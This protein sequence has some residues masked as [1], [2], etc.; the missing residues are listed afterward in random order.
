MT[1]GDAVGLTCFGL[2]LW[3]MGWLGHDIFVAMLGVGF[4]I[5]AAVRA[6]K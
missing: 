6:P 5:V 3:L 2:S 4:I 1:K